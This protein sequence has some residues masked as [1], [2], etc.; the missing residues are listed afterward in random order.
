MARG[1]QAGAFGALAGAGRGGRSQL[2]CPFRQKKHGVRRDRREHGAGRGR[3]SRRGRR[4]R[5]GKRVRRRGRKPPALGARL[6]VARRRRRGVVRRSRTLF[7]TLKSVGCAHPFPVGDGE[8]RG[9]RS[10]PCGPPGSPPLFPL[11]FC[12]VLSSISSYSVIERSAA[13]RASRPQPALPATT[14][15]A[16]HEHR[17][18][19]WHP[20]PSSVPPLGVEQSAPGAREGGSEGGG[21]AHSG[22]RG[23]AGVREALLAEARELV[24]RL[25]DDDLPRV[26]AELRAR[27]AATAAARAG[28][29]A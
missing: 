22:A 15:P 21:G 12:S 1:L 10:W 25:P 5:R 2:G 16:A 9:G 19:G 11:S 27:A 8:L 20:A 6:G 28:G 13:R 23:A 26:V 14:T 7:G 3:E 24:G 4:G 17:A 18:G 29:E